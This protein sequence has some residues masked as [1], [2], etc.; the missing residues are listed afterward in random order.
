MHLRAGAEAR[1]YLVTANQQ[2][3]EVWAD[4]KTLHPHL[5][6]LYC[7]F[8]PP[9]RNDALNRCSTPRHNSYCNY[10]RWAACQP[11]PLARPPP[12]ESCLSP[13]HLPPTSVHLSSIFVFVNT[14]APQR[15]FDF[16]LF[17]L[18]TFFTT[19]SDTCNFP[20]FFSFTHSLPVRPPSSRHLRPTDIISVR[21]CACRPLFRPRD[22]PPRQPS[23][24]RAPFTF[25]LCFT[26]LVIDSLSCT[27][28][29][30]EAARPE[31]CFDC[32]GASALVD[33]SEAI[34]TRLPQ[35]HP[36]RQ[37]QPCWRT[38]PTT[39]TSR[40]FMIYRSES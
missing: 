11:G 23:I 4:S 38:K 24:L 34:S 40:G 29:T 1:I 26:R 35:P 20:F 25:A 13:S 22:S 7:T 12:V 18:H 17:F 10:C 27:D 2:L 37:P 6:L 36:Q 33:V 19:L 5:A 16:P 15:W 14:N 30:H 28:L 21:P 32:S 3:R 31:D 8:P 9:A 39:R